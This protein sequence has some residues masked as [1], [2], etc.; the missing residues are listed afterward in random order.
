M[1]VVLS[2]EAGM[3][4]SLKEWLP[5]GV[6]VHEVPLTTTTYLEAAAVR[7]DLER[8]RAHGM[9]RTLV[10]TSARSAAASSSRID[11]APSI[12]TGL[13]VMS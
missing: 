5:P 4:D 1:N 8:S 11:R 13:W 3:N 12:N 6:T 7:N 10:V 9:Y 2:R